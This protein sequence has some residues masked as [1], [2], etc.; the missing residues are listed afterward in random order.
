MRFVD[1]EI[2]KGQLLQR[3]FLNQ[4]NFERR[5]ADFKILCQESRLDN[6]GS[7][8]L[9]SRQKRDAEIRCPLFK[10]SS[11]ILQR[12]F[13]NDDEMWTA[14]IAMVFEV[15]QEGDCLEG[16]SKALGGGNSH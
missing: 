7:L 5:D 15:G 13:R 12:R 16:F 3:P 8:V 11:P 6:F 4:T 1:D 10:L 2:F 9:G 14:G